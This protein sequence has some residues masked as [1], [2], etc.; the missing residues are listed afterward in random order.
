MISLGDGRY[1]DLVTLGL[2]FVAF[3]PVACVLLA[4]RDRL[5]SV[6]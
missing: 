4:V 1:L 5:R 2:S 6:R 3:A